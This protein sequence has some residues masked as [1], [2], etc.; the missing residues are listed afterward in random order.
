MRELYPKRF[1]AAIHPLESEAQQG[2]EMKYSMTKPC[3]AC[4]FLDTPNMKRGFTLRR[5]KE[6]ASGQFPCH[7]TAD[8]VEDED[9]FSEYQANDNSLHCAGALIFNEKRDTPNQMMRICERLGVYDRTKL[10]MDASVR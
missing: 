7:Q 6:F 8:A 3:D 10:D 2:V 4:P 5:L 9:G 1:E